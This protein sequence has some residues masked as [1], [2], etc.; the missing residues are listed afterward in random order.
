MRTMKIALRACDPQGVQRSPR[1][2]SG[3]LFHE[4]INC[5]VLSKERAMAIKECSEER[6]DEML[7]VLPPTVWVG[8]GFLVGEPHDHRKCKITGKT[9]PTYAVFFAAFGRYYEGDPMT[10]NE[11]VVFNVNDLP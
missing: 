4:T 5:V 7:G 8:K 10:V 2:T 11:F 6:Y 9:A 1:L 3:V